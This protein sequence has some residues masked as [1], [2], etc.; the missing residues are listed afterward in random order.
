[1]ITMDISNPERLTIKETKLMMLS[2]PKRWK[3]TMIP[4]WN[5]K[6]RRKPHLIIPAHLDT[7]A[8]IGL[9]ISSS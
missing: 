3:K 4:K 5:K 2:L 6:K 9:K 7:E 8:I 1:M